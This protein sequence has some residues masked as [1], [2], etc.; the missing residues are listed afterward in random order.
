MIA[1]HNSICRV[2]SHLNY[3]RRKWVYDERM[4]AD[5]LL[6]VLVASGVAVT[7]FYMVAE[8]LSWQTVKASDLKAG[9]V[10]RELYKK[11]HS[12]TKPYIVRAIRRK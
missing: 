1:R 2:S 6:V 9:I 10:L 4:R 8:Y 12:K 3:R 7:C 11:L 5:D